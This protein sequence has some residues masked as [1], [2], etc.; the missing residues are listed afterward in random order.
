MPRV[1]AKVL[2]EDA[3]L[4]EEGYE[5]SLKGGVYSA[6][7]VELGQTTLP[8]LCIM[9]PLNRAVATS[10]NAQQA[11]SFVGYREQQNL[12]LSQA[13][14]RAFSAGSSI[15]K[16]RFSFPWESGQSG[17]SDDSGWHR[18]SLDSYLAQGV[19]WSEPLNT[20]T[21]ELWGTMEHLARGI[22]RRTGQSRSCP[23]Y[24]KRD[25]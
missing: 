11:L 6:R 22:H 19:G 21:D 14:E 10:L 8:D 18:I 7:R 24:K 2:E 23:F 16:K 3:H 9:S 1:L 12:A 17:K 4:T 20:R 5:W 15:E 13:R 25:R